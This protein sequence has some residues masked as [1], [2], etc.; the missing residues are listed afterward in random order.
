MQDRR[1]R[2][3]HGVR[4][5]RHKEEPL[6]PIDLSGQVALVTGSSRGI[7]RACALLLAEAGA[8]IV[9][10]YA[11]NRE[12]GAATAGAIEALGR[13]TLLVECDVR[14]SGAVAGMVEAAEARFGR[15]DIL[16]NNAGG[17]IGGSAETLTDAQYDD[18]FD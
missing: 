17:G 14:D 11:T 9:V 6:V 10:N 13:Q 4:G 8:D 16:V 12:A 3:I 15:V 18:V 7:G 2:A 1:R 5:R